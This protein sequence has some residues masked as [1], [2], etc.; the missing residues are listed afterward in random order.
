MK[1]SILA[2]LTAAMV[3]SMSTITAFAASPVA[4]NPVA[5]QEAV[6]T[7]EAVASADAFDATTEVSEGY[8]ETKVSEATVQSAVTAVQDLLLNNLAVTAQLTGNSQIANAAA[9]SSKT[10][11]A[12]VKTVVD[13]KADSATKD[14]NGNYTPTIYSAN[15]VAGRQY[16]ALHQN[17]A[18]GAWNAIAVTNVADGAITVSTPDLSP[19]AIVELT[20]SSA[21][22]SPK[23]GETI[24]AAMMLVIIGMAGAAVCTKKIFA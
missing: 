12:S 8:T 22:T 14:A 7:I 17:T 18:T 6:T 19:I 24:P 16:V 11:T 10:V 21:A 15:I 5:G 1:K 20:V 9:D 2:A 3:L 23:T 4:A 13:I